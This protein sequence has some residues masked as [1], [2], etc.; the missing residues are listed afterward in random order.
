MSPSLL[1]RLATLIEASGTWGLTSRLK[2]VQMFSLSG[3][4]SESRSSGSGS[5]LPSLSQQ[6][7]P[8]SSLSERD[9]RI[10]LRIGGESLS[11]A[12]LAVLSNI[13]SNVGRS[14]KSVTAK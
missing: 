7:S 1:S 2:N 10:V 11:P 5:G 9:V 14:L 12:D 4:F 6:I 8:V 13:Q 3:M